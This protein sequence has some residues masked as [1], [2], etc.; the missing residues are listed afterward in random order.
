MTNGLGLGSRIHRRQIAARQG[1][2]LFHALECVKVRAGAGLRA[3]CPK[4]GSVPSSRTSGGRPRKL[5]KCPF[6]LT[7]TGHE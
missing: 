5:R 3:I 2:P 1:H 6:E 4:V 7:Q